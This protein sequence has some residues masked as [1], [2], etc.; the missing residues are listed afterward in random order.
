[1]EIAFQMANIEVSL[2]NTNTPRRRRGTSSLI[3][4][5]TIPADN[6]SMNSNTRHREAIIQNIRVQLTDNTE[7]SK[8]EQ[9]LQKLRNDADKK[10]IIIYNLKTALEN[11]DIKDK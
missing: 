9:E 11:L 4:T 8:A 2:S 5:S 6:V 7:I 3:G 1:M 10:R